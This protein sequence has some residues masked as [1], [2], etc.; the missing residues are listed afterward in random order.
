MS[1]FDFRVSQPWA[2][3]SLK[4]FSWI[5]L[6]PRADSTGIWESAGWS[7]YKLSVLLGVSCRWI[8]GKKVLMHLKL[9]YLF[10]CC[11]KGKLPLVIATFKNLHEYNDT[12]DM[13]RHLGSSWGNHEATACPLKV[14]NVFKHG[15][16]KSE[17]MRLMTSLDRECGS[18][19]R[20][21]MYVLC[22]VSKFVNWW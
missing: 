20:Y 2:W 13:C 15:E 9:W 22:H 16:I 18:C 21:D 8:S 4:I 6:Q 1:N 12:S 7:M 19:G 10:R 17:V 11:D 3:V 14:K 5:A